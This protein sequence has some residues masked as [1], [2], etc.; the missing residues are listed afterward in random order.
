MIGAMYNK[1]STLQFE[2]YVARQIKDVKKQKSIEHKIKQL[3]KEI[4]ES[5]KGE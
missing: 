2:L 4:K 3:T 5:Q 1:L